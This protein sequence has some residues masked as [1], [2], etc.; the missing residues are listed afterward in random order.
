[1]KYM[2]FCVALLLLI[3]EELNTY[4]YG[5]ADVVGLMCLKVFCNGNQEL[6]NQ[7]EHSAQK[8]GSALQKVNFL[9]DLKDDKTE[10]GRTYFPEMAN[11]LIKQINISLSNL[12][13]MIL[14]K[15]GLGLNSS[16]AEQN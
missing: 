5:S 7:L 4:I 11:N 8:L 1:M 3:R 12:S 16:R 9:R 15:H 13:K 2:A 14:T 6:Y 10:L